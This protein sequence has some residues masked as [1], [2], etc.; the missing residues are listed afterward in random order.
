MYIINIDET[1]CT[2]CGECVNVCPVEIYKKEGDRTVV[3]PTDDCSFCQ[4]CLSVCAAEAITI[5]EI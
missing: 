1:K 5:T 2:S 3:G 4:S